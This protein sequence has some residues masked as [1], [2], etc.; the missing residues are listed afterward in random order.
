[1][2]RIIL[3]GDDFGLAIPVN[4]AIIEAHCA[5]TLTTASLI[6]SGE[7][8]ADAVARAKQI[9][10]LKVGLHLVLVEGRPVLPPSDVPDLVN[11]HGEFHSNLTAAGFRFFFRPG[12][13]KQLEAEIRAQFDAFRSTDLQLDHVNAHNH[14]HLHPT[15]LGMVLRIGREYGIKAIR[16]PNEP[17]FLSLRASKD[18]WLSKVAMWLYLAPWMRLMRNRARRAGVLCNDFVFGISHSGA[19]SAALVRRCLERLPEGVTEL[20]FHPA[21]RRCPE[22]DRSMPTYDH[23]G[24]YMIL[25]SGAIK[26]ALDLAGVDKIAFCDLY[27]PVDEKQGSLAARS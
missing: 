15:V 16:L 6:V 24:E 4:E 26:T 11:S 18:A 2:K 9:P 12:V 19:M 14:M 27:E 21:T 13:R 5:G 22:I 7:A 8:A 10:S 17:P 23:E 20:Y 1:M 3:T 25:T